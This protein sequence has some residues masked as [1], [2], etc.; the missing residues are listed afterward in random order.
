MFSKIVL[1]LTIATELQQ[2]LSSSMLE[3]SF[4]ISVST[5]L[6]EQI[7]AQMTCLQSIQ[8]RLGPQEC[9]MRQSVEGVPVI[10]VQGVE[11]RRSRTV[12]NLPSCVTVSD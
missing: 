6:Y 5:F 12:K 9:P 8:V 4:A 1:Y 10:D 7:F 2:G 3:W 11:A